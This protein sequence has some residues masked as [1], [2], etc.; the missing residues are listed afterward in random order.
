MT[1]TS[2]GV[3]V[4][5]LERRASEARAH[6]AKLEADGAPAADV[7]KAKARARQHAEE[8]KA[9]KAAAKAE[10]ELARTRPRSTGGLPVI[11]VS[12]EP[13]AVQA[14]IDVLESGR[15]P[16]VYLYGAGPAQVG[17]DATGPTFVP[18]DANGLTLTF[19]NQA[20]VIKTRVTNDGDEIVTSVLLP[21]RIAS[22]ALAKT[23]WDLPVLKGIS[24]VPLL[25]PDGTFQLRPG[26][27][28]KTGYFYEPRHI[29]PDVPADPTD[30]QVQ[31]ARNLIVDKLLADF[32]WQ[33]TAD[34]ASYLGALFF[35]PLRVLVDDPMP[36][37][38]LSATNPGSGKS[39]L[40]TILESL[41]GA[42][43]STWAADNSEMAKV[44]TSVLTANANPVVIFDNLPNGHTVR[45]PVLSELATARTWN[46]RILGQTRMANV[47]NGRLWIV[48]G[49]GLG[50]GDD[51][52]RRVI[53][54]VL[55]PAVRPDLRD[56]SGFVLGDLDQWLPDHS[57]KVLH[58][59]LVLL[60]AWAAKGMP[61]S[62]HSIASFGAWPSV[63]GGI[64]EFL[65][66]DGWLESREE[67]MQDGDE[68][69]IEW[70]AFLARWHQVIGDAEVTSKTV[71][72]AAQST[73]DQDGYGNT[74]G[75]LSDAFPREGGKFLPSVKQ[76]GHW[77]KAR[78]GRHFGEYRLRRRYD[79]H[80]KVNL[81]RVEYNA[82]AVPAPRPPAEQT[83]LTM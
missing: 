50:T 24:S 10:R 51:M 5:E 81:W 61:R 59:V 13:D 29:V 31:E 42:G 53:W 77:L 70:G 11:D 75:P 73:P 47:P 44:I 19:I 76:L 71:L 74:P 69:A 23:R 16:D 49:N 25:L 37:L 22:V 6:A 65:R 52:A 2:P 62:S 1:D 83:E 12:S 39:L 55:D 8:A 14:V 58:A 46:A 17:R 45:F 63:L 48:N 82:A 32:P 64:L 30:E 20:D 78:D 3:S 67:H 7:K 9:A 79:S 56:A 41:Y 15:I 68:D 38:M 26:F 40:V 36:P 33:T 57:A 21:P 18:L 72:D 54:S 66:V 28:E 27:H 80:A 34:K 43:R 35:A 4:A 60:A